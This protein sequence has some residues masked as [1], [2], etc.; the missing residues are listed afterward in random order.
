[1]AENYA[2]VIAA[3][4]PVIS[5]NVLDWMLSMANDRRY[6]YDA[7]TLGADKIHNQGRVLQKKLLDFVIDVATRRR[8]RPGMKD[9]KDKKNSSENPAI[10]FYMS[11]LKMQGI[12]LTG[13]HSIVAIMDE[14]VPWLTESNAI[15]IYY[16]QMKNCWPLGEKG[17]EI[18]AYH[19]EELDIEPGT[20]YFEIPNDKLL[21]IKIKL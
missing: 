8:T 20:K 16:S 6:A 5:E 4:H 7:L 13:E 11:Y 19:I 10:F 9:P 1:M 15:K 2:R 17:E 12:R 21:P 3:S 18:E 14:A